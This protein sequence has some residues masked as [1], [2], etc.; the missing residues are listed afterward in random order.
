MPPRHRPRPRPPRPVAQPAAEPAGSHLLADT[1]LPFDRLRAGDADV[2]LTLAELVDGGVAYH[3]LAGHL[4]VQ[5][6]RL[7]LDPFTG[8]WPGGTLSGSAH[9]DDPAA[10]APTAAIVLHAPAVALPSLLAVAGLPDI[11]SGSAMLDLDLK[12][13]GDTPQ[14]LAASIDGQATLSSTDGAFDNQLL[15]DL[16]AAAHLPPLGGRGRTDLRCLAVRMVAEQGRVTIEPL[17]VDT[18]RLLLQGAGTVDLAAETIA[19]QLRPMLRAGPGIVVP[20]HVTGPLRTPKFGVDGGTALTGLLTDRGGDPC[21]AALAT[22]RGA[23][24]ALPPLP[25]QNAKPPKPADLLRSLFK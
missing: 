9:V 23:P 24:V 14:A 12:G 6:G 1:K 21:A 11:A 17:V 13:T 22:I 16:M 25:A 20:I 8:V 18:G 7:A 4:V 10:A 15:A 19:M 5:D 3:D 2:T